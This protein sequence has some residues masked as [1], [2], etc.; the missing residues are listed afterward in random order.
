MSTTDPTDEESRAALWRQQWQNRVAYRNYLWL[1][2]LRAPPGPRQDLIA[3]WMP[4][5]LGA[6]E[7]Q[8][9]PIPPEY[10]L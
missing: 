2:V 3:A 10:D 6:A 4:V 7:K 5:I 1:N 9:G 8:A